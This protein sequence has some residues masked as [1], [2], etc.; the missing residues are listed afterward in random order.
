L[1]IWRISDGKAGHDAQSRGLTAELDKLIAC[2]IYEI[3]APSIFTTLFDFF[4]RRFPAAAELPDPDIIIGAGHAAHF[5]M[6]AARRARGGR[7]VVLMQPSLPLSW[8]DLCLVPEHD[9]PHPAANVV[10]TTG[11]L[12]PVVP[13]ADHQAGRGLILIGGPS[14]HYG[15]NGDAIIEQVRTITGKIPHQWI[16]TNSPRTPVETAHGLSRLAR[17]GVTYLPYSECAA[18]WLPRQLQLAGEVWVS[19]DSMSMIFEALTAGAAVGVLDVPEKGKRNDRVVRAIDGL[20]NKKWITTYQDWH[21]GTALTSPATP[22]HEAAR[23][24]RLLLERFSFK[25][26]E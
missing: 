22:L 6:L 12:N 1:I 25:E 20:I 3:P 10:V 17:D 23:C 21:N 2:R 5:P 11:P 9:E 19:R 18:G 4:A 8:F 26:N 7:T 16:L 15:W 14:R 24:A 13:S